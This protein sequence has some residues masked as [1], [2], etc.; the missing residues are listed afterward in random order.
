MAQPSRYGGAVEVLIPVVV[1]VAIAI[2]FVGA[3]LLA[4]LFDRVRRPRIGTSVPG[5]L[6]VRSISSP[7]QLDAVPNVGDLLPAHEDFVLEGV[8]RLPGVEPYAVVVRDA[9]WTNRWPAPGQD[10]PVDV[11]AA[12][13]TR[14]RIRWGG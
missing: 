12:D 3:V 11:D 4:R 8:V 5:I 6:T 10:V 1:L 2:P 7:T 13:R 9:A 14:V